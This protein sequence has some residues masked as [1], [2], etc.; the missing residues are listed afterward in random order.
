MFKVCAIMSV[1]NEEDI[2]EE[3]IGKLIS[4]GIDVYV[5]D[6]GCTDK[7]IEKI[8]HY[9]GRGIV[10]IKKFL[11][12]E[13]NKKMYVWSLILNEIESVSKEL[14]YDWFIFVDA[15]EIR[16]SPWP[17][18]SLL[19][20]V[21][22]VDSEG[23]NL[24]NFKLYNFR[25]TEKSII[26][27]DYENSLPYY[28]LPESNSDIQIK[29][30]KKSST[31]NISKFGG[32]IAS[33]PNP[34]L[35]PIKFIHKHYPIRSIE[36]GFKKLKKERLNIYSELEKNKGW[37]LHYSDVNFETLKGIIWKQGDLKLYEHNSELL[38]IHIESNKIS[39][40]MIKVLS[41]LQLNEVLLHVNNKIQ[42]IFQ[43]DSKKS[44]EILSVINKIIELLFNNNLPE[45]NLEKRDE[46]IIK[47]VLQVY[48][49]YY[50][51]R[52]LPLQARAITALL[53]KLDKN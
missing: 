32:H 40:N 14:K 24:I 27:K 39:I 35:Y 34:L 52:A 51:F 18:Y 23:Y 8:S 30:W 48:K 46:N 53:V 12:E 36:H 13:N 4:S 42:D 21:E 16:Y 11:T 31:I 47:Y 44:S 7:T 5:L 38:D 3:T 37:H 25:V 17:G 15:D 45:L 1:Y 41:E 9:V 33:V 43:I 26:C 49:S 28:S 50:E 19:E 20:G 10:E 6:N 22:R 2:I 29:A